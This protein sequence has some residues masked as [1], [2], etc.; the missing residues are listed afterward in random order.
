[1]QNGADL[2]TADFSVSDMGS[3]GG[4]GGDPPE[5]GDNGQNENM[6][7]PPPDRMPGM[8]QSRDNSGN[9]VITAISLLILCFAFVGAKLFRRNY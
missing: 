2:I 1:M 3:M 8:T 6:P 9:A 7:S 5:H 4:A